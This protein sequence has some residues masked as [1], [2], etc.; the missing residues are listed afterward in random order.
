MLVLKSIRSGTAIRSG[1]ETRFTE[2][3]LCA[4]Q[5][6]KVSLIACILFC[7]REDAYIQTAHSAELKLFVFRAQSSKSIINL[8]I[9]VS[10]H[11]DDVCNVQSINAAV[12]TS[13]GWNTIDIHS[14]LPMFDGRGIY[15]IRIIS[16]EEPSF[17]A[18]SKS[19]NLP[20]L[21]IDTDNSCEHTNCGV[22]IVEEKW[23]TCFVKEAQSP[24]VRVS[25]LKQGSYYI[26]NTGQS[27]FSVTLETSTDL[28][29]W[30]KDVQKTLEPDTTDVLVAKYYGK[31]DRLLFVSDSDAEAEVVFIAQLY[32]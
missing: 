7:V 10:Q 22:R 30:V 19:Y 20:R 5:I 6:G 32:T 29:G 4:G 17:I 24:P 27:L 31:Y 21:V 3:C 15:E 2:R 25:R 26:K 13:C 28:T 8:L 18:F 23:K 14:F 11:N 9:E 1:N 16:N 12:D